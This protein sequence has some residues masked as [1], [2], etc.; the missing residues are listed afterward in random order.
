MG[1]IAKGVTSLF[2][3]RARRRE[4]KAAGKELDANKKA[5]ENFQFKNHFEGVGGNQATSQGYQAQQAGVAELGP[6]QGYESQGYDAKGYE[7]QGYDA[8][9]AEAAQAAK[10]NLGEDTGR[11]NQFAALQV[12]TAAAD[13]AAQESDQALAASQDLAAQAG[14]GAGGATALAAAALKAKQGVSDSI[15]Q[16]EAQNEQLRA[17]GATSVQQEALAQRNLARQANIQQD[18]FN[19]GLD[20]QTRLANQAATNQASQFSAQAANEANRFTAGAQNDAARFGAQADNEAARFGASAQNQFAQ[21]QFGAQNQAN[22]ANASAA[23]QAAAFTAGA[24][25]TASSQNA[26]LA[27][28]AQIAAAQGA[29]AQEQNKFGIVQNQYEIAAQRKANADAARQKATGDLVGGIVGGI[30]AAASGGLFGGGKVASA[31]G[32]LAG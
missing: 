18:Q 8:A 22:L 2:G 7:G 9:Q 12:N 10:T 31:I 17:Q 23:N 20:Q 27:Q 11:T 3:G 6:A 1:A 19:T 13:R 26:R 4:Q 32:K 29:Q 5:Y 25:N 30:G 21:A 14:S 24:A 28:E 16:Q 15:S